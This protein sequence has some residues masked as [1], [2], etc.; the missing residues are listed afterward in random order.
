MAEFL[1]FFFISPELNG[2]EN[3]AT[4][5]PDHL[6][7]LTPDFAR[8]THDAV[9]LTRDKHCFSNTLHSIMV[10]GKPRTERIDAIC[11]WWFVLLLR[12][13]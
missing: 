10:C 8:R 4:P 3:C 2:K 12:D 9:G 5:Q 6:S 13:I 1:P 11:D 7:D